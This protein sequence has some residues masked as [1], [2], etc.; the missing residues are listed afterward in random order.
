MVYAFSWPSDPRVPCHIACPSRSVGAESQS[1]T[2]AILDL[3]TV[4][5]GVLSVRQYRPVA[6]VNPCSLLGLDATY[7]EYTPVFESLLTDVV[8]RSGLD[9]CLVLSPE[10]KSVN[11]LPTSIES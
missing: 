3:L 4:V 5:T 6:F 9:A 10:V 8:Q 2:H 1:L 7:G 11:C